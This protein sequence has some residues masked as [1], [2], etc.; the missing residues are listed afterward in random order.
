VGQTAGVVV[1]SRN[2]VLIRRANRQAAAEARD[3]SDEGGSRLATPLAR[4]ELPGLLRTADRE[5]PESVIRP[6]S[7]AHGSGSLSPGALSTV[8]VIVLGLLVL[9]LCT[10]GAVPILDVSEGRYAEIGREMV[11]SG[12]W[13]TPR[14]DADTPFWG[15]P[16]LQ[17][18]LLAASYELFG[19]NEFA[20]RFPSFLS[21][22]VV[23]GFTMW[24]AWTWHGPTTALWSAAI[25]VSMP[26]VYVTSAVAMIDMVLAACLTGFWSCLALAS[27]STSVRKRHLLTYVGCVCLGLALL[28]KGPVALALVGV[29][30][31]LWML[32]SATTKC[33]TTLPWL[34]GGVVAILVAAPWY[35]L[36]E[37]RTPGFLRY[38]LVNEN[39]FRF[40]ASDYGDQYG[41]GHPYPYA[42]IW[43]LWLLAALPWSVLLLWHGVR[44][45]AYTLRVIRQLRGQP[46]SAFLVA[47]LLAPLVLFTPCRNLVITYVLPGLVPSALLAGRLVVR[48]LA[49]PDAGA[50]VIRASSLAVPVIACGGVMF[51]WG[52]VSLEP[53]AVVLATACLVLAMVAGGSLFFWRSRPVLVAASACAAVP[54]VVTILTLSIVDGVAQRYSAKHVLDAVAR[55]PKLR[56]R[57]VASYKDAYSG[58]FYSN[59]RMKSLRKDPDLLEAFCDEYPEGL[60][61]IRPKDLRR[62]PV[63]LRDRFH[64]W[65]EFDDTVLCSGKK[66]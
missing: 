19:L 9:R 11:V 15:K 59:G 34:T 40:L 25:L 66:P 30:G 45:R 51:L 58:E 48:M 3:M 27:D 26:L 43:G 39:L 22:L 65:L 44:N 8:V 6:G 52:R 29:F 23:L 5:M 33:V 54:I 18:W 17:I 53:A 24:L 61:S 21:L 31:L 2:L 12:D 50:Q 63:P 10:L 57:P 36:A 4:D 47:W 35:V 14:L 60:V 42:V 1:C 28:A 41:K 37:I 7:V 64:V 56:G 49:T 55:D 62:L 32:F 38:F 13:V 46:A 16:P 20:A